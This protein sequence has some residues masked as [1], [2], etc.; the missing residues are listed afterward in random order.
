MGAVTRRGFLKRAAG[1]AVLAAGMAD[2]RFDKLIPYV[3]PPEEIAPGI[4]ATFATTCRECPAGCGMHL[5]HRD[6][7]VTKAEGI[8]GH[9]IND[10]G[11]CARGQSSLQGLYDPDRLKKIIWRKGSSAPEE[12]M[13]GMAIE[14]IGNRIKHTSGKVAMIS[15]LQTGSL[16]ELM[17]AFMA[18]FG[19][20]RVLFY[21]PFNYE[22]LRAAHDAV[23][24]L[25]AVPD[26]KMEEC[27]YVLS[28]GADFLESWISPVRFARAY[29]HMRTLKDG[30]MGHVACVGPRLSM[31]AANADEFLCV[32]PGGEFAVAMAMLSVI[33]DK[34]W[35]SADVQD[36]KPLAD[37]FRTKAGEALPPGVTME[38]VAAM[39]EAFAHAKNAVALA[40]PAGATGSVAYQT[41]VAAALLNYATGRVGKT[42][43]FSRPQAIGRSATRSQA[44]SFLASLKPDDVL[45]I[46]DS[47]PVYSLPSAAEH[48]KR[49]GLVVYMGTM[50]DETSE[51]ATWVLPTHSPLEAWGDYEPVAGVNALM[52][53]TMPRL[54]ETMELGD[55]L[56]GFSQVA[57][58]G[59]KR[60]GETETAVDL[61]QWLE[62]RWRELH[63]R[64]APDK[65]FDDF[66]NDALRHG[67]VWSEPEAVEARLR[68]E[69]KA[70]DLPVLAPASAKGAIALCAWPSVMLYDGRVANRGWLQEAP[71][72]MSFF[73]WGSWVDVHPNRASALGIF[74]GDVLELRSDVGVIEA[75]ARVTDDVAEDAVAVAYGQGHTALGRNAAGRGANLFNLLSS[76]LA[77]PYPRV[78]LR[79]TG[80]QAPPVCVSATQ[81]QSHREILQWI[82]LSKL[83]TMKPG[84]GEPVQL[85]LPEGYVKDKDV[86]P[87]H[88]YR[89]HRWVMVVDLAKCTG[90]GACAVACYAENNIAI[91]GEALLRQGRELAWLQVVPYRDGEDAKRVGFIPMMC[92]HCD[93]APCE[94]VCPVFASVHNDEGLN[95]QVYNRCIGTRYCA[96]NCPYKARRFNW[97]D[98]KFEEPLNLQLN[99]EVSVRCRGVMEKCTFCIQRIRNVEHRAKREDR[100]V[101]DG[102][103]Q[104]ACSQSC[105]TGAIYF[106]DLMDPNSKV[107]ELTRRDPRRY[108]VLEE[109]STKS[110][111]TYLRR[112]KRD[113]E[114]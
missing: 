83:A 65:A 96:N 68:P 22:P 97:F 15:G 24:G 53:P 90:C 99:P 44:E 105:P 26:Y 100:P 36:I 55:I 5:W 78:A 41:A 4:W 39:A 71:D 103:I 46:C 104:T 86:F 59:V 12:T 25:P 54:H 82:D 101:R 93:S 56:L 110:A 91:R 27:D 57:E 1:G 98:V 13:W 17:H 112:I 64:I 58:A 20:D 75:P 30:A 77:G 62:Q 10:G 84:D 109:L 9:P 73:V 28:F 32:A 108:H 19:S 72:P 52:Q 18:A 6:G 48:I 61:H 66:W 79:K 21:E 111:V 49:A 37:A 34:G 3:I 29:A 7:R 81:D 8:P 35:A 31:T 51:L 63:Q 33:L 40:G 14:E 94:P 107:S 102:E 45:F 113:R 106:G 23:F 69:V 2:K 38:R 42:V 95:A 11:L 87:P 114:A 60:A 67:G 43:D 70:L 89:D 50:P 47:N 88:E 85:P 76:G 16:A 74:D 80:R 92:Q